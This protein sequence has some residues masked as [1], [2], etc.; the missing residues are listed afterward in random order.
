MNGE[1]IKTMKNGEE[2]AFY[3]RTQAL[4]VMDDCLRQLEGVKKVGIN[5]GIN[6]IREIYSHARTAAIKFGED[7]SGYPKTL[8][9]KLN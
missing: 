6:R 3:G 4:G 1:Y 9:L 5:L 7:T 8:K 2:I